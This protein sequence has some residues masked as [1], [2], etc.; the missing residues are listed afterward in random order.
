MF[1]SGLLKSIQKLTLK[2]LRFN[3]LY[4]KKIVGDCL[5]VYVGTTRRDPSSQR[6]LPKN[7]II[8]NFCKTNKSVPQF[9][10]LIQ[11]PEYNFDYD[12]GETYLINCIKV[13]AP[14]ISVLN[15][16]KPHGGAFG[17]DKKSAIIVDRLL[18]ML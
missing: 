13:K 15:S 4:I 1:V 6:G 7:K 18:E 9:V 3:M 2:P 17:Y 5:G 8:E 10:T 12:Y 14:H 16:A 11:V